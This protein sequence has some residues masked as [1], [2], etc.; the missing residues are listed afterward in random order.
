VPPT[1]DNV[2]DKSVWPERSTWWQT[3]V[4]RMKHVIVWRPFIT[5]GL[6]KQIY[7]VLYVASRTDAVTGNGN[8]K[9]RCVAYCHKV[10]NAL[11]ML[12]TREQQSFQAPFEGYIDLLC[13]KVIR[14]RVPDC[15]NVDVQGPVSSSTKLSTPADHNLH[16]QS[17]TSFVWCRLAGR[18][19][20]IDHY[21]SSRLPRHHS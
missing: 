1:G 3:S 6:S 10:A 12:V 11:C 9:S 15:Q 8:G 13:M 2:C 4:W 21:C 16:T 7:T 17:S 19:Q 5:C 14:Q 18:P 20:D